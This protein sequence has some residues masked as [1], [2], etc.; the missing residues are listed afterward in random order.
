MPFGSCE[1]LTGEQGVEDG[2]E[3]GEWLHY[4]S[5]VLAQADGCQAL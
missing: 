4:W 3:L 2:R 5:A 1:V